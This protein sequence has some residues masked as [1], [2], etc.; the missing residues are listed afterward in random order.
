MI[1]PLVGDP[2][3]L[4]RADDRCRVLALALDRLDRDLMRALQHTATAWSGAGAAAF[5]STVEEHRGTIS[6]AQSAV[7][8]IGLVSRDWAYE[9][10]DAQAGAKQLPADAIAQRAALEERISRLRCRF[11]QQLAHVEDDV[12]SLLRQRLAGTVR[13]GPVRRPGGRQVGV[14][15]PGGMWKGPV[16]RPGGRSINGLGAIRPLP[17]PGAG[18]IGAADETW[19][20]PWTEGSNGTPQQ[21]AVR[22]VAVPA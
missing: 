17:G 12:A 8:R 5:G 20:L 10:A 15:L 18:E 11:R 4:L 21:M 7:E 22:A 6:R 3:L 1:D 16:R 2:E 13:K 14:P 9:L 19:T